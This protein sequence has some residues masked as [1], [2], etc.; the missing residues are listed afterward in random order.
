MSLTPAKFQVTINPFSNMDTELSNK[1]L[2]KYELDLKAR[3]LDF[4][5]R[6]LK[7]R[8]LECE[9]HKLKF[10]YDRL[11]L[12]N[13]KKDQNLSKSLIDPSLEV[14]KDEN[15][16]VLFP[17]QRH[18]V[19]QQYKTALRSFWV[20][21]EIDTH[22]D[23]LTWST[24]N[25]NQQHFIKMV[26]AF[27]AAS[28]GIVLENLAERFMTDIEASEIR[29]FYG[30]QIAMENIHSEV[31]SNLIDVY[32]KDT[33]EKEKL[34]HAIENFAS[35]KKKADWAIKWIKSGAF[36]ATR[37]LAF[38]IVEGV[39][40]SG[41]FASIFWLK[42]QGIK[43]EG[44]IK[45]N[46]LISRDEGLHTKFAVTLFNEIPLKY[47]PDISQIHQM[48]EE[49]VAAEKE[50]VCESLPVSLI[51][52][53]KNLMSQYIEYVADRLL[54][55]INKPK[56]YGSKNPFDFMNMLSIPNKTD[57]FTSVPT[58]YSITK[59]KFTLNEDK[60]EDENV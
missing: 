55:M 4:K 31:Y 10:E 39:F 3:E 43:L 14:F 48:F 36:F 50:F 27:F 5:E 58:E 29:C 34:F 22:E 12:V 57:F 30:F 38:A 18:E 41:A 20:A 59:E 32:I 24:L 54:V 49:A 60:F 37:L 35:I 11:P 33:L 17:I 6:E 2:K 52:M 21:E 47:Q 26:L 9:L 16:Y 23:T 53:N 45:S 28:D 42:K 13:D 51:G 56:L 46:E 15:R 1:Q 7:I 44:L 8:Q 19:W 40:F 25:V